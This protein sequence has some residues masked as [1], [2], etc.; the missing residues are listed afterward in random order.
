MMPGPNR[1][2]V[3]SGVLPG[4]TALEY[5]YWIYSALLTNHCLSR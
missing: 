5:I 4:E 3:L 1:V 2:L